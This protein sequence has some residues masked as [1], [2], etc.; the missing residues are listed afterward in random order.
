M[1][2]PQ[3]LVVRLDGTNYAYWSHVVCNHLKGLKLSKY[4]THVTETDSEFEEY[5]ADI[6]KINSW[7]ANTMDPS[8][9]K[10]LAKFRK[11]KETWDSLSW[12][13]TQS[14]FA[15]RYQLECEIKNVKQGI[16]SIHEFYIHITELWD[17]LA[18]MDP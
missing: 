2:K 18:L 12:L 14:S 17:Q 4:I 3:E 8:I 9:G 16:D 10:Q 5:D 11:P 6:V 13:Y 7:I 15:K 1:E